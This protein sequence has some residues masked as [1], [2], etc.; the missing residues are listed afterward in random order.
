[1]ENKKSTIP[2]KQKLPRKN[3]RKIELITGFRKVK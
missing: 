2:E 1:M 3:K